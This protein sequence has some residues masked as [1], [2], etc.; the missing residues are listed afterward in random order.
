MAS[1][2]KV[3]L[4]IGAS[5]GVGKETARA[6][7]SKGLRVV[8]VARNA[9]GLLALKADLGE[10]LETFAGDASRPE[11]AERLLREFRPDLVVLA[12]GITP[13]MGRLDELT[14]EDFTEAWNVD[15]KAAFHFVQGA[16]RLPLA[17]GS[18]VALL[19]SG[20]AINGSHLSGGYAGAK[21]MQWMMAD[22]AQ[23]VSDSK[24]LGIR[25]LAVLPKQLIEG[26]KIAAIASTTYGALQGI[27]SAAYMK[28]F[29]VPLTSEKVAD[30]VVNGFTGAFAPG[31][32]A[33]G[34]TGTGAE[35]LA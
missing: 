14:W 22:Y 35:P 12:G 24:Q 15:L 25:F 2:Q 4:V 8:G 20:A 13:R 9:E 26:T 34:V 18:T 16:L 30:A 33:I 19:S 21:R 1:N 27:S 10:N 17:S 7:I 28:Q 32:T 23:K 29:D 3:A 31:V 6:L 5:S 11:T